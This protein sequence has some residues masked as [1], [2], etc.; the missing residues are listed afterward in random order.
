MPLVAC[1]ECRASVSTAAASCPQCGHPM[2]PALA[3][4]PLDPGA[5]RELWQG[6]PSAKALVGTIVSA[7]LFTAAVIVAV[8]LAYRPLLGALGDASAQLGREVARNRDTVWMIA[9]GLVVLLVGGRLLKLAWRVAVLKSHHYRITNQRMVIESGVFSRNIEEIDMRTVEDLQFQ[10]SMFE[11]L[12]GIGDITVIS[13]D[14]TNA[15]TRLVG[16]GR[17]R[18]LR[19]LL[20]N[21]AYQATNRQ[22]FTRQT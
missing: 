2:T 20:R 7:T 16:L 19:E 18:E 15:H 3:T 13:S 4:P 21:A 22:L 11:R 5:E 12:L 6:R 10:Q 9:V 8:Y 14:R 17:P 1:P